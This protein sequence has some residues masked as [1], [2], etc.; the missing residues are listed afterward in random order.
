MKMGVIILIDGTVVFGLLGVIVG[1]ILIVA[2][3]R[4]SR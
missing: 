4:G 2:L 3:L 1:I